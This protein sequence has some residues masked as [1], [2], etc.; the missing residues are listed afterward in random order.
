MDK[1]YHA[2]LLRIW[3]SRDEPEQVWF[4]SLEDPHTRQILM[5]PTL[6]SMFDYLQALTSRQ[7]PCDP[8]RP[9]AE[10]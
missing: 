9:E 7:P 4:A 2:Y 6:Q 3:Q 10:P 5:F 8:F 1:S